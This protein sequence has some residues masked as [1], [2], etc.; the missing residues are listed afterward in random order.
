MSKRARKSNWSQEENDLF[1]TALQQY[2]RQNYQQIHQFLCDNYDNFD[3]DVKEVKKK[4]YNFLQDNILQQIQQDIHLQVGYSLLCTYK[5]RNPI[6]G[7]SDMN[8]RHLIQFLNT[9]YSTLM[10]NYQKLR[11]KMDN[12]EKIL[13]TILH[14]CNDINIDPW[15]FGQVLEDQTY[16]RILESFYQSIQ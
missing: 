15:D 11:T 13:N 9:D 8:L 12:F 4:V 5:Q 16:I 14:I 7:E 2:G 6:S 10:T 3:R 1:I